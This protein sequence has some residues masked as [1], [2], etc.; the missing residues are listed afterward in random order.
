MPKMEIINASEL[1]RYHCFSSR[2]H[3]V[4]RG[5]E[6]FTKASFKNLIYGDELSGYNACE[7][8]LDWLAKRSNWFV[9]KLSTIPKGRGLP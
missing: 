5:R 1:I 4:V 3:V 2:R 8:T 6:E 7:Y 9:F